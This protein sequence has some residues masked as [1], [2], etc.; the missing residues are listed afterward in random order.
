MTFTCKRV[1]D[2]NDILEFVRSAERRTTPSTFGL[3]PG[4][5]APSNNRNVED[6]S[7][8]IDLV[9]S[10]RGRQRRQKS[11]LFAIKLFL[12]FP[13]YIYTPNAFNKLSCHFII[14]MRT[15][16]YGVQLIH[17]ENDAL[18]SLQLPHTLH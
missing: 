3:S 9:T 18:G 11:Y 6:D 17:R 15:Q 12:F 4:T 8:R 1:E 16:I 2:L 5:H 7:R 14:S 13:L 10:S